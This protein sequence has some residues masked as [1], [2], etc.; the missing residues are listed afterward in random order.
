MDKKDVMEIKEKEGK[1]EKEDLMD[2]KE[3]GGT[4]DAMVIED[5]LELLV[6]LGEPE[7]LD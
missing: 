1:K 7:L 3:K 6:L 4:E 2:A 5:Q